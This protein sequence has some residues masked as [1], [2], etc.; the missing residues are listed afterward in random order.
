M[1]HHIDH[2]VYIVPD[3]S[4]GIEEFESATGVDCHFGGKHPDKGTHN[5]LLRIGDLTYFEIL[6]PDPER[7]ISIDP[8]WLGTNYPDQKRISHWC[9][10][11]DNIEKDVAFLNEQSKYP[12]SII[13][14]SRQTNDGHLLS[15]ELGMCE[16]NSKTDVFPF[17]INWGQSPHPSKNLSENCSI[18]KITLS[19]AC[20][21]KVQKILDYF[22]LEAEVI[23]SDIP[24]ITLNL[25][26]P[27]SSLTLS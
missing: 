12:Y 24:R 4:N 16:K 26:T 25:K 9:I 8:F 11:T 20:P 27:K 21:T 1:G 15:W 14:G 19:H 18:K 5:A 6:A 22:Q 7:D 23:K 3:L 2:F 17:L 13:K 10:A